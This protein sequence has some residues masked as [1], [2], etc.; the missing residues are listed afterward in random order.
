MPYISV[1]INACRM[2]GVNKIFAVMLMAKEYASMNA[3]SMPLTDNKID[4]T[5][6]QFPTRAVSAFHS[7]QH[8]S[9]IDYV[10]VSGKLSVLEY[11]DHL[12]EHFN[13][14]AVIKKGYYVTPAEPGYSVK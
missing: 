1:K 5:Y 4:L 9:T 14:P 12:H 2:I 3:S 8:L 10:C 7:R 11:V 13:H 6:Q